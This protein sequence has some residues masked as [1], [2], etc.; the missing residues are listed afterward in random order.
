MKRLIAVFMI[1]ALVLPLVSAGCS[2]ERDRD[3][4]IQV[5][6]S[7]GL[8]FT[9]SYTVYNSKG[10]AESRSVDGSVPAEYTVTGTAVSC[11]FQKTDKEGLLHVVIIKG[12]EIIASSDTTAAYGGVSLATK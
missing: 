5:V 11:L 2:L 9:G 12:G 7:Q 4:T 1:L 3:Y 10:Q 6:G 8:G